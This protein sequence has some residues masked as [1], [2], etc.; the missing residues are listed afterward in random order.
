MALLSPQKCRN[1]FWRCECY[2]VSLF[3]TFLH[4]PQSHFHFG[5]N[6]SCGWMRFDHGENKLSYLN[7]SLHS[8]SFLSC[9][10]NSKFESRTGYRISLRFSD[11]LIIFDLELMRN[12]NLFLINMTWIS[13]S[14]H[15]RLR[16]VFPCRQKTKKC[17]SETR[18]HRVSEHSLTQRAVSKIKFT[19]HGKT[20]DTR[21]VFNNI[22]AVYTSAVPFKANI[23]VRRVI[24]KIFSECRFIK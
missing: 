7:L 22:A 3:L 4:Q 16:F 13:N 19:F 6:T 5:Y 15:L 17:S 10:Q 9:Q 23:S 18:S 21:S 24:T 12:Q 20:L 11:D 14:V 2:F 1:Y 8:E